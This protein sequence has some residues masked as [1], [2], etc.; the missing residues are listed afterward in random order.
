MPSL[1]STLSLPEQRKLLEDLNYLNV[2]EIKAFC[3]KHS[4]PY[5]IWIET[6]SGGRK[7]TQD[8]DR[9][10][11]ILSRIRH[12]LTTAAI[13][14]AT[15]FPACV[16]CFDDLP[17]TFKPT[18]R[19]FYGQ[20]DKHSLAMVGLLEKLTGGRFKNGAVARILAR[21]FWC[22][23]IA[24]TFQEY[25]LAWLECK[26]LTNDPIP[27][28]PFWRTGRNSR[29]HLT[30]SGSAQLR[31]NG[32]STSSIASGASSRQEPYAA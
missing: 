21:E 26:R 11:V 24:P 32:C 20:Y 19:L 12:Y 22:Q 10:G 4:I 5:S 9:K 29:T 1:I 27:N 31:R 15:C 16:V 30:G 2:R 23:G 14:D 28:G 6:E 7:K 8:D 25:A 3:K 13:L 17:K 18:D